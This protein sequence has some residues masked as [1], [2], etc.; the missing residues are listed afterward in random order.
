MKIRISI[1][2]IVSLLLMSCSK[3]QKVVYQV[4]SIR[5]RSAEILC[6]EECAKVSDELQTYLTS[7]WK[8]VV[9]SPKTYPIDKL[10][11][12]GCVCNGTEYIIEK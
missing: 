3:K 7:G 5:Y 11:S 1:I 8:V 4:D 10:S 6:Q 12:V 2:F 9:S